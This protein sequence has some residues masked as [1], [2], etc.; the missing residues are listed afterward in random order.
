MNDY[1]YFHLYN[2]V[3]D[4]YGTIRTRLSQKIVD[5]AWQTYIRDNPTHVDVE[6]FVETSPE[7]IDDSEI[8]VIRA[9]CIYAEDK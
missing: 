3:G 8:E 4:L 2:S 9:E 6:H 1:N 5:N 7:L